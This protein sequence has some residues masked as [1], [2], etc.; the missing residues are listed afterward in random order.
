MPSKNK[1]NIFKNALKK[2]K[3]NA[4]NIL[5]QFT[6]NDSEKIK[7]IE[8]GDENGAIEKRPQ[9]ITLFNRSNKEWWISLI[10]F[11]LIV[12]L[13]TGIISLFTGGSS[14][15]FIYLANTPVNNYSSMDI[16][17]EPPLFNKNNPVYFYLNM[18]DSINTSSLTIS[19]NMA[20]SSTETPISLINFQM[21]NLNPKWK[22]LESHFQKELFAQ[23]G[24]YEL[25]ISKPDNEILAKQLFIIER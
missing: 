23:P 24:R 12:L 20:N 10:S 2:S 21:S 17:K 15:N 1:S 3:N 5:N 6:G 14:E 4:E 19:L 18:E 11:T 7:E 25:I 8:S 16:H 13:L 9:S 22:V